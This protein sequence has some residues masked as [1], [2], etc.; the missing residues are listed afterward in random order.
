MSR[1]LMDPNCLFCKIAARKIPGTIVFEN[2][3]LLAFED[4]GRR[5]H[6]PGL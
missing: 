6:A 3:R 5:A 4:I 1:R 2:E